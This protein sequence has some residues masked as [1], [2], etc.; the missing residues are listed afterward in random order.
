[1]NVDLTGDQSDQARYKMVKGTTMDTLSMFVTEAM[2]NGWVCQG[3]PFFNSAGMVWIQAMV[4]LET[5]LLSRDPG[6]VR[7]REPKES[8]SPA[9]SAPSYTAGKRTRGLG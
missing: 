5:R 3:S 7:L 6:E 4:R 8:E 2:G 9:R 1:M